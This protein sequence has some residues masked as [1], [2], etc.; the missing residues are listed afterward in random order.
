M[1]LIHWVGLGV[2][3]PKDRDEVNN[4]DVWECDGW[5]WEVEAIDAQSRLRLTRKTVVFVSI[6]GKCSETV[7]Y[8]FV[9]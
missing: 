7:V 2:G 5:V 3:T 6:M 1:S 8:C 4:R 9:Y